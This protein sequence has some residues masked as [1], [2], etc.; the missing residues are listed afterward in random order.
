MTAEHALTLTRQ[1]KLE[2]FG[3]GPW[4]DEPDRRIWRTYGLPC[5]VRRQLESGH[6]CGYVAVFPGHPWYGRSAFDFPALVHGSVTSAEPCNEALGVCHVP[7][8]GESDDAWW[9]GFDCMHGS[10]LQ[11]FVHKIMSDF[12]PGLNLHHRQVYRDW[13]YVVEQTEWLAVQ[14]RVAPSIYAA[15]ARFLRARTPRQERQAAVFGT[16][17][18]G[19]VLR[20]QPVRRPLRSSQHAGSKVRKLLYRHPPAGSFL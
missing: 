4:L 17:A 13:R 9:V 6:L 2:R 11:P 20:R 10:D 16:L 3:E 12:P 1:E 18:I 19:R 14:A 5:I 7:E 8:L 15:T